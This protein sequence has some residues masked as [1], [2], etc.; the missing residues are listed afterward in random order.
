MDSD[1]PRPG[2]G[3]LNSSRRDQRAVRTPVTQR[4][5]PAVLGTRLADF[6]STKFSCESNVLSVGVNAGAKMH[7][8]AGVKM[9]QAA[10]LEDRAAE[11]WRNPAIRLFVFL[12]AEFRLRLGERA[13]C[14]V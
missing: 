12:P 7:R 10:R 1:F 2:I 11:A 9:H 3:I 4:L 14:F 5:F 8:R 13:A 6:T